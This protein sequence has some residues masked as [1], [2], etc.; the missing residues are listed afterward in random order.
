MNNK[1]QTYA[2]LTISIITY[3]LIESFYNT[4]LYVN[5]LLFVNLEVILQKYH[6]LIFY[7]SVIL[8]I[9][10]V[11]GSKLIKSQ[12]KILSLVFVIVAFRLLS[13]FFI[14]PE[15]YLFTN[16]VLLLTTLLFFLEI[17]L[18]FRK[19]S[20]LNDY[21]LILGGIILGISIN[22][23]FYLV[24]LSSFLTSELTKL[25]FTF[26]FAALLIYFNYLLFPPTFQE[27]YRVESGEV[28]NS[29]PLKNLNIFHSLVLG[30]LFFFTL[31]WFLNPTALSAYD[32]LNMSYNNLISTL[33]FNWISYGFTHYIFIILISICISFFLVQKIFSLNNPKSFKK[34]LLSFSSI[35]FL[36]N[37]LAF[38]FLEQDLTIF[39][40]IYLVI[41][42]FCGVFTIFLYTAFF[43][44]NYSLKGGP[45]AYIGMFVFIL[46]LILSI[47]VQILISW[48]QYGSFLYTITAL[49]LLCFPIFTF[50]GFKNIG[51]TLKHKVQKIYSNKHYGFL[52]LLILVINCSGFG[53]LLGTRSITQ[54]SAGNPTFLVYNIHNCVGVD[55]KFD[56]DRIINIIKAE[57]PDI[58]G[59]NEVDLGYVKTGWVDLPSYFAHK[60]NM[61]YYYGPTFYKHYGNLI[62]SKFPILEAET[63]ALPVVVAGAEP[64]AV[65]R[66]VFNINSQNWT[67][68]ITHLST[69]HNDRLAQVDYTYSNSVVSIINRSAFNYVV[70]MGDFNFDPNSTEYSM[71]NASVNKFRDTY[72]FLNP[73]PGYTGG[74]DDNAV[75]HRR[76]DYILC[77]PDLVPTECKV[78]CSIASDH[79][80]VVTKF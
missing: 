65:T 27:K 29:T 62:L 18:V 26:A 7:I 25:P 6:W 46:G 78:I 4:C 2:I 43:F 70:W 45:K 36:L 33:P 79:C 16:L 75:P 73:D 3:F 38:L 15:F 40:T 59:L 52:F 34:I 9:L 69:K 30:I 72:P 13:Q 74:F 48:V 12:Y 68:Y 14:S 41:L 24:N 28:N 37:S 19:V 39:S 20:F 32:T 23:A 77:S 42:T 67:V 60:L 49:A 31:N 1:T 58:V 5:S 61:Y 11:F 55:A 64:R 10:I 56:I 51:M 44:H 21:F 63:F 8:I 71:L 76:I 47:I 35:T 53:I 80:A 57:D 17:F 66:A 22:Y 54:P 50:V